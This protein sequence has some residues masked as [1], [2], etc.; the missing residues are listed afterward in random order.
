[1]ADDGEILGHDLMSPYVILR[2]DAR[3]EPVGENQH[4]V[5]HS[6]KNQIVRHES[7][8]Q[9]FLNYVNTILDKKLRRQSNSGMMTPS[10]TF[11]DQ[12]FGH[13]AFRSKEAIDLA[14]LK[15]N[16]T[17]SGNRSA[18]RFEIARNGRRV[19]VIVLNRPLHRLGETVTAAI[20]FS[21]AELPCFFLRCTMETSEK[22]N[23]ALA[24]RSNTSIGRVTRR[25]HASLSENTLFANRIVFSPTIPVT[26]SPT[27]LTSGVSLEWELRFE[28][29]TTRVNENEESNPATFE[30]LEKISQDDRGIVLAALE[31]LA[32]ETFEISIP[33]TVY[34]QVV[35]EPATE[36]FEVC[37]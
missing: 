14:I 19:G 1:M 36:E 15:S 21:T 20:D 18:N 31:T 9:D 25:I 23:P 28:F 4:E 24:L 8:P 11:T 7:L 2:D 12:G 13:V 29:A 34:G 10:D 30:I 32:S 37:T 35:K 6:G 17:S 26:S 33:I 5:Q 22:V 16:H 3:V 27:I